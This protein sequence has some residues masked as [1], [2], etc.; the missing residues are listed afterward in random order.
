MVRARA[1][2]VRRRSTHLCASGNAAMRAAQTLAVYRWVFVILIL[3]AS[4][5]VLAAVHAV[6]GHAFL[7]SLAETAGALLLTW[8]K[9]QL[10]GASLL[11][12]VFAVAEVLSALEGVWAVSYLL[13]AAAAVF[14]V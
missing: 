8:R 14:I 10:L 9:T 3:V 5:R 12:A 2:R 13:Y 1:T 6:T 11:V 4:L 7:L